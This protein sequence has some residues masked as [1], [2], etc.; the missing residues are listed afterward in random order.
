MGRRADYLL[1]VV[2]AD[3]ANILCDPIG[4]TDPITGKP[5]WRRIE[6]GPRAKQVG[7]GKFEVAAVP[8]IMAAVE[9][10][11]ARIVA[12]RVLDDGS[13]T[14]V[15]MSGPIEQPTGNY[16]A[17]RDSRDGYG[18]LSVQFAD[19]LAL[20][21][22]HLVY[23]NPAQASTAQTV[24]RY[25]V[26]A[27]NPET[28][29][30]NLV[31]LNAGPGALAARRVPGLTLAAAAGLYPGTTISTSWTRDTILTD[32]LRDVDK[33]AVATGGLGIGFRA[34]QVGLGIQFQT[35]APQDLSAKVIFSR[36]MGN[37]AELD[38]S[39]IAPTA[40]VALVG[41][42]TAGVGRVIRE[43]INAAAITAGWPRIE[44]F[45]D[46][47]GAANSTEMDQTGDQALADYGP[48]ARVTV[49][50][51]DTAQTRYGYAFGRD[52]QVSVQPYDGG[53]FVSA[54]CLGADI[55]VTPE[56]G[57]TVNPIIGTDDD[58]IVFDA[59]AAEIRAIW[60]SLGKLQGAL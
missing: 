1:L 39:V 26:A 25:S 34:L 10:P 8:A 38:Y 12:R 18:T 22:H 42:A 11:G 57:E 4:A 41:D 15:V 47:R 43:R 9:T 37:V 21:S 24:A 44:M 23:P 55:V 36:A 52:D 19:D 35:Y 53:P 30:R 16:Q 40:T 60:R 54:R 32:A 51:I 6:L 14:E 46:A 50:G 13:G 2:S 5:G 56:A 33:L 28:V 31:N 17:E 45:V 3:G 58:G 49:K 27:V 59:K 29:T 48:R 7:A 20:M